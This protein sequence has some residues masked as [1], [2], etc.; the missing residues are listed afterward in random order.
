MPCR[1]NRARRFRCNPNVAW[2]GA[3]ARVTVE[4][5]DCDANGIP[6]A[7]DWADCQGDPACG[8]CNGNGR[9]DSCDIASGASVDANGNG[10]PDECEVP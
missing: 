4:D 3:Y 2:D 7:I 1:T 8:N 6:D 9:L 10:I 5:T